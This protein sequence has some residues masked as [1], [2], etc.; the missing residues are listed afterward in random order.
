M[1]GPEVTILDQEM[2]AA[3]CSP[4]ML[5][6]YDSSTGTSALYLHAEKPILSLCRYFFPVTLRQTEL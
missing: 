4:A 1:A 6:P 3:S 2:K 5:E